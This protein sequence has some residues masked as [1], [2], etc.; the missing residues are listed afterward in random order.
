[1]KTFLYKTIALAF[2][3]FFVAS[4][5][6]E[7]E[8]EVRPLTA[9]DSK[10]FG[11][12]PGT[13]IINFSEVSGFVSEVKVRKDSYTEL[14]VKITATYNQNGKAVKSNTALAFDTTKPD[15][16]NSGYTKVNNGPFRLGNVLT[17][18]QT[19]GQ[20]TTVNDKGGSLE[21][22]FSSFGSVVMRGLYIVDIEEN[23]RG[24]TLEML[25]AAGRV[26]YKQELPVTGA[27][28]FQPLVFGPGVAGVA[29]LR[30]NFKTKDGK[31]GSGAID[32][33]QF[34]PGGICA[35]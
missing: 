18:G 11:T 12:V 6:Q 13:T 31:G 10:N 8:A 15:K 33:I 27:Y 20:N 14:P 35:R 7:S 5:E 21:L 1:M 29:K 2:I 17:I 22:D 16:K 19:N 3:S 26:I 4:C 32:V 23:E 30:V 24:S 9:T 34:C 28:T 25:D